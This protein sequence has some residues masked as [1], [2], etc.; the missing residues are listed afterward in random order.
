[1]A[2]LIPSMFWL[3]CPACACR[4]RSVRRFHLAGTLSGLWLL[5]AASASPAP[6]QYNRAALPG[7][8]LN[9]AF[10]Q[11]FIKARLELPIWVKQELQEPLLPHSLEPGRYSKVA[12]LGACLSLVRGLSNKVVLRGRYPSL[13]SGPGLSVM[14][15]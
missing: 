7:Q 9:L 10:G 3:I 8:S 4:S 12:P 11:A 14:P 2:S 15:Q 1:M 13:V 6:G 5:P